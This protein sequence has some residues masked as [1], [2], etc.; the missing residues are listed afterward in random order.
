M[1]GLTAKIQGTKSRESALDYS[2]AANYYCIGAIYSVDRPQSKK[3]LLLFFAAMK[4]YVLILFLLL[5]IRAF[6]ASAQDFTDSNLPIVVIDT[7]IDPN[8]GF[9]YDI[10]DDPRVYGSM[11]IIFHPDGARNY[12]A[13]IGTPSLLDY[14]GRIS[15]E[16]RGST[17]QDLPKKPYGLTTLEADDETNNNVPLLGMPSENDWVLNSLA[18]DPSLMRD[19]LSYTLAREIGDYA[20]RTVYCEVVVNGDYKG[21]YLLQEK[22]KVDSGRVDILKM[23]ASDNA[24]PNL[25]G[26][27]IVKADKTTGDDPVAWTMPSYAGTTDYIFD[28][29]KPENITAS[30]SNYIHGRFTSLQAAASAGNYGLLNGV[31]SI[32]DIPTFIDFM[33]MSEVTSNVDSYQLSSYFHQDRN[34]KLRAGPIWDYNL[35]LGNDLFDYGLDRSHTDVWQF[36]NGDNDGSKF[37]KDMFDSPVFKCLLSRRWNQVTGPDMPLKHSHISALIDQTLAQISEA[38]AREEQR[39]GTVPDISA[40]TQNMK[41]WLYS[42]INWISAHIG[43]FAACANIETPPLVISRIDY[44]PGTSGQFPVSNDQEFIEITNTGSGTVDLT[45]DYFGELGITYQFPYGSTLAGGQRLYLA[46]N[47]AVF[48]QKYG[49]AAFGQFTRNLSNHSQDLLLLDAFGDVI[50]QVQ[51]L[52][53]SPWPD[54]DGNGSYLQLTD[55][56]LDNSLGENWTASGNALGNAAFSDG[57]FDLYPNPVK[58]VLHVSGRQS[59]RVEIFDL[60]GRRI[61][62]SVGDSANF[63]AFPAGIYLVRVTGGQSSQTFKISKS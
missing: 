4:K 48:Q 10:P 18:F 60:A 21:L 41:V 38:A 55:N 7:D 47:P 19:C 63:Q 36:D 32:I 62:T 25:S 31:P 45:G 29:P 28:S 1:V 23:T 51:Y 40:E 14:D 17:S 11:R 5:G 33:I 6:T 15:I 57:R 20:P 46:S 16:T 44:N 56:S 34:G 59:V 3:P 8:T 12:M 30:Q 50:D 43:P 58:D 49:L 2:A 22:I 13:D 61:G 42:R 35:T 26:G 52:D 24:L 37:W 53:V 39:W 9:P 27:Y 54:A